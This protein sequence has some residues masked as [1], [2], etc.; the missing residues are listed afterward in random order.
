MIDQHN[1]CITSSTPFQCGWFYLVIP[2]FHNNV[3]LCF[4]STICPPYTSSVFVARCQSNIDFPKATRQTTFWNTYSNDCCLLWHAILHYLHLHLLWVYK[5]IHFVLNYV[6][7]E[8]YF[9]WTSLL[10]KQGKQ[11]WN[12]YS[13]IVSCCGMSYSSTYICISFEF[14]KR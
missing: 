8:H 5:V 14:T 7:L 10:T 1:Q 13:T 12:M 3:G 4:M 9:L 11:F 6:L 2:K